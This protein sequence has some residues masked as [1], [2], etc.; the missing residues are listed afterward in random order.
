MV[1]IQMLDPKTAKVAWRPFE[2]QEKKFIDGYRIKYKMKGKSDDQWKVTPMIHRDVT[3]YVLRDLEPSASYMVDLVFT[4]PEGL[5]THL[6]SSSPVEMRTPEEPKDNYDFQVLLRQDKVSPYSLEVSLSGVPEPITKYVHVIRISYKSD[7]E[8]EHQNVF[9][10][11][12]TQRIKLEGLKPGRRYKA[13]MDIYLTN[14]KSLSS[15]IIDF[16]TKPAPPESRA[17]QELTKHEEKNAEALHS[18]LS[19]DENKAYYIAL[20]VVAIVAAVAGL[21]F[22]VLLII[23]LKKQSTAKAPITRNSSESAY[24]NPTYKTYDGER[25]EEKNSA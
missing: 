7:N 21:G 17:K 3:S 25:Y 24:D 14:G 8:E 1:S 4:T 15:N 5:P 23:I 20:I 9:K 6:V 12:K 13:W 2:P 10:V 22:V 19:E 16:M 11:P 18:S